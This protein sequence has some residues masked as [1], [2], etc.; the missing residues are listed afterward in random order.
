MKIK[1]DF[2]IELEIFPDEKLWKDADDESKKL[3][4]KTAVEDYIKDNI[5]EI[6]DS[7]NFKDDDVIG[8]EFSSE[9][10]DFVKSLIEKFPNTVATGDMKKF[11]SGTNSSKHVVVFEKG[12][13]GSADWFYLN[14]ENRFSHGG[15]T[16]YKETYNMEKFE[17][18]IEYIN[19]N[20][21]K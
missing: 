18:Y 17:E 1:T 7:I 4:I 9:I 13:R 15:Y 5:D 8:K 2:K 20:N 21:E 14:D 6:V 11:W 19:Y 12:V 16:G 3:F 10:N